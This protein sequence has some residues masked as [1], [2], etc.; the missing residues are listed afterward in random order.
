MR[1]ERVA[2]KPLRTKDGGAFAGLPLE[3]HYDDGLTKQSSAARSR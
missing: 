1:L 3:G 2:F